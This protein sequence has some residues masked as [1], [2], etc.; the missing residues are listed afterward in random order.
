MAPTC[1][2]SAL[3]FF[4]FQSYVLRFW[5]I[6]IEFTI[7]SF[8]GSFC[9]KLRFFWERLAPRFWSTLQRFC[10][11]FEGP[12]LPEGSKYEKKGLRK[13]VVFLVAKKTAPGAILWDFG[14]DLGVS[15]EPRAA[16]KG[17]NKDPNSE[18]CFKRRRGGC[19]SRFGVDLGSI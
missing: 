6:F 15:L 3:T 1:T 18:M 5:R 19:W 11:I 9:E 10:L 8:L 7:H 2:E 16:Q 14:L 4:V 13:L 17:V 12:G